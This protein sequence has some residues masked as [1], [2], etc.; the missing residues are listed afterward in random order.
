MYKKIQYCKIVLCIAAV[1]LALSPI[2][3]TAAEKTGIIPDDFQVPYIEDESMGKSKVTGRSQ[4]SIPEFF[5]ARETGWITPSE[6]QNETQLCWA[7]STTSCAEAAAIRKGIS[8]V[9]NYSEMHL[10]YFIGQPIVS[11]LGVCGA[12]N[13]YFIENSYLDAGGNNRYTTFALANWIGIADQ[14]HYPNDSKLYVDQLPRS[15]ALD[16]ELHLQSAK[17][18]PMA[19]QSFVK[20]AILE[21]G[22]VSGS[23][24]NNSQYFNE[25]RT[26][27]YNPLVTN[28]NHSVT[29]IGWD[30]Y[31]GKGNFSQEPEGDG[32]WLVKGSWGTD[33]QEDGCYWI[34]YY[35]KSVMNASAFAFDFER[36]DNYDHNYFYDGSCG[37]KTESIV[38]GG[39]AAN[40]YTICGNK[41][42]ADELLEA[43]GIA[44]ADSNVNYTIQIFKDLTDLNIPNSGTAVLEQPIEGE[45]AAAGYYTIPLE[46]EVRLRKGQNFSVVVSMSKANMADVSYFVDTT[47]ENSGWI[48]FVNETQ[49]G[50]SFINQKSI[51]WTDLNDK[52]ETV[53]IKAFTTDTD[54]YSLASLLF[55]KEEVRMKPGEM[56]FQIPQYSPLQAVLQEGV[57]TSSAPQVA[58]VSENGLVTAIAEGKAIIKVEQDGVLASYQVVVERESEPE[59]ETE[60]KNEPAQKKE[61]ESKEEPED[62]N[63]EKAEAGVKP[64]NNLLMLKSVTGL[65]QKS[66]NSQTVVLS[67]NKVKSAQGYYVYKYNEKNKKYVLYKTLKGT[68]KTS[69]IIKK[70]KKN[71]SYKYAVAAFRNDKGKKV[72][73]S[74]SYITAS[75]GTNAPLAKVKSS[76]NKTITVNWK[77]VS[78]A[79]GYEIYISTQRKGKF[80]KKAVINSGKKKSKT[81]KKLKR[82]KRYYVKVRTYKKSKYGKIYS[83]F[84]KTVSV[85][86]Q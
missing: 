78:K 33:Y 30:D 69:V 12:D 67:W 70:L 7:Y 13:T 47:Y 86:V 43:V 35:D 38:S 71:K 36:A 8:D 66:G 64:V 21:Y 77:R 37:T 80:K 17:W 65:K 75:T 82:G 52:N 42:G 19:N 6:N 24:Y 45:I 27:Y 56:S 32:A 31:F 1:I 29:I 57:W 25:S 3:V 72:S 2:R 49:K 10:G 41:N 28:T 81:I 58:T 5:D 60:A 4:T 83:N 14:K 16:D 74:R 26:A 73:G 23:Y 53:R 11:T 59:N 62:K 55:T 68:A 79:K 51:D 85:R 46:E 40:V 50:Q 9:P 39:K 63:T 44:F 22:C 54:V 84:S 34:S 61:S 15:C 20:R 18:I 48:G 76:A